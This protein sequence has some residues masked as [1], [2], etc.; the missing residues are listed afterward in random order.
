MPLAPLGHSVHFFY[1]D[2]GPPANSATY[3]TLV[4]IHGIIFHQATFRRLYPFAAQHNLRLVAPNLRDY[5]GSTPYTPHETDA[6]ANPHTHVQ[7]AAIQAYGAEI[8]AFL[9]WLIKTHDLPPVT[10]PANSAAAGGIALLGW[11][12]GNT[13]TLAMLAHANKLP[14]ETRSLLAS[15]LRT[16]IIFEPTISALGI[17]APPTLYSPLRDSS[18]SLDERTSISGPWLSTHYSSADPHPARAPEPTC[19][20][21]L[22]DPPPSTTRMSAED[23]AAITDVGVIQRAQGAMLSVDP[24]IYNR[25]LR[26]ALGLDWGAASVL[27]LLRIEVVWC[28]RSVGDCVYAA[29]AVERM[30]EEGGGRGRFWGRARAGWV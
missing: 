15:H 23:L 19:A 2:T 1:T 7:D 11:S 27:P 28:D 22:Q 21:A 5:P 25:N 29:W 18:I 16:L 17:D 24:R 13:A 3:T 30:C 6:F 4:L 12:G 8:A 9:A 26:K 20:P 10:T 14:A